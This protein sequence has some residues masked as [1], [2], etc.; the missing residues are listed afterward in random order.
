MPKFTHHPDGYILMSLEE[1][2]QRVSLVAWHGFEPD[3]SIPAGASGQIYEPGVTHY[4]IVPGGSVIL[5]PPE[6][7]AGDGYLEKARR[8]EYSAPPDPAIAARSAAVRAREQAARDSI[9]TPVTGFMETLRTGDDAEV[10][11]ALT[12]SL[13]DDDWRAALA[14]LLVDLRD[15]V[16]AEQLEP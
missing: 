11:A 2:E 8:G 14:R 3:Y 5:N 1:R 9:A 6:W 7:A 16:F 15:A 4:L 13:S 12:G 10:Q